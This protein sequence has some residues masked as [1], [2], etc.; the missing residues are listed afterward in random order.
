MRELIIVGYGISVR[1]RRGLLMIRGGKGEKTEV[2]PS[3]LE[4]VVVATGGA[5]ISSSA[6][7]LLINHGVDLVFLDS[8]G[9]PIG[10][11][12]PP[13][14]NRT[15]MTRRQQY[16][17]YF[18]EKRWVIVG[19]I[20]EAKIRNQ[21]NLLKYYAKSREMD[22]LKE[23]S[24]EVLLSLKKLPGALGDPARVLSVEAEASRAYW[25]GIRLLLPSDVEF[26]GRDPEA[27]DSVNISINY[28]NALLYSSCWKALVLAG[29]DPYAGFLHA[30][31]SGKES[32]VYDYSD[33]FKPPAVDR[34]VV[35]LF[36]EG[37]R[38]EIVNGLLTAKSRGFLVQSFFKWMERRV[39]PYS[40]STC[41]L[42][43]AVKR[44][45]FKLASFL[46][47]NVKNY[48]GFVEPW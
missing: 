15:V 2:S 34:L 41:S 25:S 13:F 26:D 4:T 27:L 1:A 33:M 14:I 6:V 8:R 21:A 45:A 18:G 46:R 11:L 30:D 29:L 38:P 28:L 19:A 44:W 35:K 7:R 17:A 40:E 3:D 32:L 10:R 23:A 5:S 24:Y 39:R 48:R 37:W 20:V 47:G 16:E 43:Q 42:A 22:E 9:R 12:Y 31:R 36:S